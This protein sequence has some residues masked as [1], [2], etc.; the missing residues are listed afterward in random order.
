MAVGAEEL[1]PVGE[2]LVTGEHEASA[3]RALSNTFHLHDPRVTDEGRRRKSLSPLSLTGQ[4]S[5]HGSGSTRHVQPPA[6]PRS[7]HPLRSSL[8]QRCPGESTEYVHRPVCRAASLL[9]ILGGGSHRL[10]P[11]CVGRYPLGSSA[12]GFHR[13][14]SHF[15]A[16]VTRPVKGY[17]LGTAGRGPAV[18]H[19]LSPS[20]TPMTSPCPG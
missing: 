9:L 12:P 15:Y 3:A 18:F 11:A 13:G 2:H 7:S 6:F 19:L 4:S 16:L 1:S 17:R 14:Q 5:F 10:C 20:R 8:L